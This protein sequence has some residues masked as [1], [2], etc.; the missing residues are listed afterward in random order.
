MAD[1]INKAL[2]IEEEIQLLEIEL[3]ET[4]EQI[5]QVIQLIDITEH[6]LILLERCINEKSWNS[7]D[8]T[9]GYANS[10]MYEKHHHA[11][12]DFSVAFEKFGVNRSS[13]E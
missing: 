11:L 5:Y 9:I 6:Q 1:A 12:M 7:I 4:K 2:E 13:S 3:V 10:R 8:R